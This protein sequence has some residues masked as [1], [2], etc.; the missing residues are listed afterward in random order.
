MYRAGGCTMPFDDCKRSGLG[1]E[2]GRWTIMEYVQTKSV[3]TP[4]VEEM[5]NPCVI[6]RA[7]PGHGRTAV[8]VAGRTWSGE[9]GEGM[10]NEP[11]GP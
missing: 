8:P 7:E 2:S 1:R 3:W 5:A 11:F 9:C 10:G 6:D 4:A